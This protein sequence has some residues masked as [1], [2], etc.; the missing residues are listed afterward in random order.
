MTMTLEETFADCR[1]Q[2][3][4]ARVSRCARLMGIAMDGEMIRIPFFNRTYLISPNLMEDIHGKRPTDAVGQVL[5]RYI[6][7][8]PSPPVQDGRLITFRELSGAGPLVSNFARNT[9]KLIAG[10]FASD[11]KALTT[12]SLEL[13]GE[14]QTEEE[15]TNA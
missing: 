12:R 7:K 14:P 15:L 4:D 5:C 6:L 2:I 1:K 3:S 11:V 10:T 9:N 8:Y 13:N